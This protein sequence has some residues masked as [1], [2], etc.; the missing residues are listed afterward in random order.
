MTGLRAAGVARS[1]GVATA[2]LALVITGELIVV[3]LPPNKLTRLELF[4]STNVANLHHHP[5]TAL[6]LSA[7]FPSESAPSSISPG[8]LLAWPLLVA[9]AMFGANR[10]AGNLWLLLICGCG[11]VV[12]TLVSEG[13]VSYRIE[14]GRLPESWLHIIDVGPSYVVV[15]AI[16]V[17]AM[18]GSWLAKIAAVAAFASLVFI[19]GIFSG[20]G[21]FQVAPVGH[22]TAMIVASVLSVALGLARMRRADGVHGEAARDEPVRDAQPSE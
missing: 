21:S 22:L 1:Y 11:Q 14:H 12:G 16:V 19:G 17:A 3:S 20:L 10:A 5:V 8:P 6:V 13:I 2:F 4:A 7:L 9:L 18:L 15:A